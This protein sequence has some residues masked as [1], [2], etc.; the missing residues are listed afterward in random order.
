MVAGGGGQIVDPSSLAAFDL[1]GIQRSDLR[2]PGH[3]L[4]FLHRVSLS[5]NIDKKLRR[6]NTNIP[7]AQLIAIRLAE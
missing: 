3:S 2:I 4:P 6:Q 7:P 5:P 1:P